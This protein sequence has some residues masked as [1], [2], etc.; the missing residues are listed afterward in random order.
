V[1]WSQSRD[2][3]TG[4]TVFTVSHPSSLAEMTWRLPR[5]RYPQAPQLRS[6]SADIDGSDSRYWQVRAKAGTQ[7]VFGA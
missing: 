1:S 7:L 6:G 4:Q 3:V 5:S 2:E